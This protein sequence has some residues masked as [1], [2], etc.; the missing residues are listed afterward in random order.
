MVRELAQSSDA[1]GDT[2]DHVEGWPSMARVMPHHPGRQPGQA[3]IA[4]EGGAAEGRPRWRPRRWINRAKR[5]LRR[6]RST[7]PE[8]IDSESE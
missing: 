4:V 6:G 7:P 8:M 5:T 3:W 2:G 1:M